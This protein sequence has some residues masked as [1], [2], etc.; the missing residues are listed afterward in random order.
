MKNRA[1]GLTDAQYACNFADIQKPLTA[2]QAGIE[3]SRCLFC[4]E[5]PC[6]TACPAHLDIPSF[7]QQIARDNLRNQE[8]TRDLTAARVRGGLAA[9]IDAVRAHT[10]V[11][12]T[13][14]EIPLLEQ[15]RVETLN[16]L[17][18]LLSENTGTWSLPPTGALP[19]NLG[20]VA[21]DLP[22]ATVRRN[23]EEGPR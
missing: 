9:E 2:A 19:S 7:I 16:T 6:I 4:F 11:E 13:R 17:R 5:A 12:T 1:P 20:V 3:S 15:G 18:V 10:N 22:L 21:A 8:E 14:A 23:L